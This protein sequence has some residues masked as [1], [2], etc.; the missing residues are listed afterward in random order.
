LQ[1][2]GLPAENVEDAFL[3]DGVGVHEDVVKDQHLRFVDGKFLCDGEAKAE[4][5]LFLGAL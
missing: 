2:G 3:A 5:E 4:E 1:A